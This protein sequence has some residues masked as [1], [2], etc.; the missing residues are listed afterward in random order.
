MLDGF[1]SGWIDFEILGTEHRR[2]EQ[3]LAEVLQGR[4]KAQPSAASA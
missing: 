3:T 4:L 2:G 1:N